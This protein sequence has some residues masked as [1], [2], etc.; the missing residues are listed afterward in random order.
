MKNKTKLLKT[1]NIDISMKKGNILGIFLL[2]LL[3][4]FSS[5]IDCSGPFKQ[6]TEINLIQKCPS[7][8]FVNIT[9][10]T[11]PNGT[12]FLNEEME[13]NGTNFNYTLPDSSQEGV[14]SYGT[15]GDKDGVSP[16]SFEELCIIITKTGGV[17]GTGELLVYIW[18]LIIV[19]AL[20]ILGGYLSV[21]IPYANIE[22]E[23]KNGKII[24]AI[25]WTKYMKIIM[26]WLTSGVLLIF[27]TI[28]TGV[29]NNYV[30]FVEM[31]SL[32]TNIYT[33]INVLSYGL[34]TAVII[35][36][37]VNIYKDLL[38]NAEIRKHGKAFVE[39]LGQ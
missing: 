10:I 18:I 12:I 19:A 27:L 6:D 36:L 24:S 7:C 29:I 23:T 1:E 15:I 28:L 26:I 4:S 2:I 17:V 13:K 5:A 31:K 9:S 8:T 39:R 20:A 34:S 38:W 14:V 33:F 16:P 22:E 35:F 11:Y 37:F 3:I 21:K 30:Q 32:F 25:T